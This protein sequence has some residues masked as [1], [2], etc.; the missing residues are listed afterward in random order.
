M[1]FK[2]FQT[3]IAG[4]CRLTPFF[5]SV[6]LERREH[7]VIEQENV[8]SQAFFFQNWWNSFENISTKILYLVKNIL[9]TIQAVWRMVTTI[10][11]SHFSASPFHLFGS[12]KK[13]G[14]EW[15]KRKI[16]VMWFVESLLT[17]SYIFHFILLFNSNT[18]YI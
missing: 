16:V 10:D 9:T 3:C 18:I 14:R 8:Y 1:Y 2:R 12:Q 6:H 17:M 7:I 4:I 15:F 13:D 11:F 5:F